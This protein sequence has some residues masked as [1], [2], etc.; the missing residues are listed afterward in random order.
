MSVHCKTGKQVMAQHRGRVILKL[1]GLA[2]KEKMSNWKLRLWKIPI[3][4]V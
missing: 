2:E 1:M 4:M 3:V